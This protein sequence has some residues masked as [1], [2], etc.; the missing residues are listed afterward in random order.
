MG[1]ISRVSSRTYR[2][3]LKFS[4]SIPMALTQNFTGINGHKTTRLVKK[5]RNVDMKGVRTPKRNAVDALALEVCGL[6]PYQKRAVELLRIGKDKRCLKF[7]K[8]RLGKLVAAKRM[9]EYLQNYIQ[10]MR[11]AQAGK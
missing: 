2:S 3:D 11:K 9:G 6:S 4:N 8:H 5:S 1:L 10:A 7:L